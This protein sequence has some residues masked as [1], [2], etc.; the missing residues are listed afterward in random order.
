MAFAGMEWIIVIGLVGILLLWSP[1]KIPALARSLGLAKREFDKA[2]RGENPD[3]PPA[4][5]KDKA[6]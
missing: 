5:L 2:A 1:N 6:D 3:T 4:S